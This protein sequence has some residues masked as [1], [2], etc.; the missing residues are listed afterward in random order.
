MR[1]LFRPKD[2]KKEERAKL[3]RENKHE[4]A[5]KGGCLAPIFVPSTPGGGGVDEKDEEGDK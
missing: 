5:T 4:W 2:W 1:P 3:K